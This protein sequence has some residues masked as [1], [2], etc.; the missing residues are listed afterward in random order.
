MSYGPRNGSQSSA[1]SLPNASAPSRGT[2]GLSPGCGCYRREAMGETIRFSDGRGSAYRAAPATGQGSG[3][4]VIHP[5]WGLNAT[6]R[7]F[8]DRLADTGFV[9]IAPDL[10]GGTVVS[11][12]EDAEREA[13]RATQSER[14]PVVVTALE[15]LRGEPGVPPDSLGVLGFSM[16]AAYALDV[17]ARDESIAAAVVCY[18]TGEKLDWSTSNA[19]VQ[20]HFAEDDPYESRDW[21]DETEAS[22]RGGGRRVEF[23][24]YPGTSHWFMEPDR[25]EYSEASANLAWARIVA[26]L[27]ERLD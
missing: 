27:R 15:R 6:V 4:L 1:S 13:D 24:H 8:C 14:M 7:A 26:F 3:V 11:T 19:A 22:I 20:G 2:G 12:I 18:G 16:G 23:Y 9:V 17:A 25:P 5:W 10:Y 21:I